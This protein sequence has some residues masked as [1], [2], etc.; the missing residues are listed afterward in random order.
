MRTPPACTSLTGEIPRFLFRLTTK[1]CSRRDAERGLHIGVR[2]APVG[3]GARLERHLPSGGHNAGD[4]RAAIKPSWANQVKIMNTGAIVDPDLVWAFFQRND[5]VI[6]LLE[7]NREPGTDLRSQFG[8]SWGGG[9]Y[10]AKYGAQQKC[11][12]HRHQCVSSV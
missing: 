7:S 10:E 6:A 8:W 3:I 12:G 5:A 11:H 1:P 2:I 4:G 9:L